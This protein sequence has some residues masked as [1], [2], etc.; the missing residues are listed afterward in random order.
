MNDHP[1]IGGQI[2]PTSPPDGQEGKKVGLPRPPFYA[3]EY[4]DMA[5][6]LQFAMERFGQLILAIMRYTLD[7]TIPEDLTPDLKIMFSVYQKKIDFAREKYKKKC[8]TNTE[9]GSKGGKAKAENSRKKTIGAKFTPPTQKQFRDAV[10]HF[11]DNDEIPEDTT[12]YDADSFFD[13]LKDSRWTIGGA[14]IQSRRD[15]ESAI[16]AKFFKFNIASVRHLYYP[17]F[18]A[19]FANFCIDKGKD[20]GQWAD[21]ATYDFMDTYD[22]NSE[23]WIVQGESFRPP[24]WKDALTRFIEGYSD[25]SDT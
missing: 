15:W 7:E 16:K 12:D 23:C 11:A 19:I 2:P 6:I 24:D 14:P 1:N 21:N 22:E 10:Q 13:E 5:E 9:N 25:S 4:L 18:S 20:G 17:V 3:S 8:A